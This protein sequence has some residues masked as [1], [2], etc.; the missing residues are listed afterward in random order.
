VVG[1]AVSTARQSQAAAS[2]TSAQDPLRAPVRSIPGHG[3]LQEH[4]DKSTCDTVAP[5]IDVSIRIAV[6]NVCQTS[7]DR[8]APG[9][10]AA[11]GVSECP[12]RWRAERIGSGIT[13]V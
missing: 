10:A 5:V 6:W 11:T 1:K 3:N 9:V 4:V 12:Q 2:F 7:H 13:I 8:G